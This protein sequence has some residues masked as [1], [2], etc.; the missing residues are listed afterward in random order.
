MVEARF[1]PSNQRRKR[2]KGKATTQI[3]QIQIQYKYK[4]NSRKDGGGKKPES[5]TSNDSKPNRVVLNSI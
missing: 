5:R 2:S 1:L 4:Y 3:Q